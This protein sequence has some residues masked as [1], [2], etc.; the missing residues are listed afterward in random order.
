[1]NS[2]STSGV[3]SF[4]Q[5][6][7]ADISGLASSATTDTTNASNITSGTLASARLPSI[8]YST[9]TGLPTLGTAAAQNTSAFQTPLTFTG[10]GTKTASSTGTVTSSDCAKWDGN[11][12]VVDSGSPCSS[13]AALASGTNTTGTL[14]IGSGASLTP[15]GTGTIT[16]NAL[17]VLTNPAN[18]P[19]AA[20]AL[21]YLSTEWGLCGGN[22]TTFWFTTFW[23]GTSTPPIANHFVMWGNSQ[24]PGQQIDTGLSASGTGTSVATTTGTPT[25]NDCAKW[26]ANGN[27]IDAGS[28]CGSSSGGSFNTLTGGTNTSAALVIGS[29]A[30]LAATGSGSIAATSVPVGGVSSLSFTGNTTKAASSTGTVTTSDCAKWDANG[31]IIDSGAPCATVASGTIGQFAYY[32]AS[33]SALAAHSLIASDIPALNYQAPLNFTG[34]G[35][36]AV[37][38][39]AA[40][41]SGNCAKWDANGNVVDAGSPCGSGSGGGISVPSSTT[42]GNVPQYSTASGTSLSTGLGVVTSVGSP[43]LDTNIP[44]EKSVRTA[45]AAAAAAAGNMPAQTGTSGYL[46]TNGTS[47]SWGNLATGASGALDCATVPGVCDVVTSIVPLKASANIFT[48]VNK[49]SQLQ[50]SIYT[51][52]TLPT[53]NS[54]LEGQMEGVSDASSPAYLATVSG[55]G[56]THLPVYCNGTSWVAY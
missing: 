18:C 15:T 38:S 30:S 19:T 22:G 33:G 54:S 27:V 28:P 50:V 21:A 4:S 45:I 14:T 46:I 47:V 12:N 11:G 43:G 48:G 31:N 39:T 42:V 34:S 5:P 44:T 1:M 40:G 51:V 2:I 56:S 23:L 10:N 3:P 32:S 52:A 6:S 26:D 41:T 13:W 8:A 36:K 24:K 55:G 20:G 37:S 16:A 49:F 25:A 17:P 9:L 35:S 7:A 53:C 29:G